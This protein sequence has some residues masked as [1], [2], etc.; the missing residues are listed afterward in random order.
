MK[1]NGK[2]LINT[3]RKGPINQ[4]PHTWFNMVSNIL[5]NLRI[6]DEYA[7]DTGRVIRE[8]SGRAWRIEAAGGGGGGRFNGMAYTPAGR[9]YD[10]LNE[11]EKPWVKYDLSTGVITEE[12][13]PP[14]SPWGVNETWRKK[15][16]ASGSIYF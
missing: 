4:V 14:A 5:N 16:D 13:G 7:N 9:L 15:S 6:T 8:S 10:D 3:F 11:S 12:V 2:V 1:Q